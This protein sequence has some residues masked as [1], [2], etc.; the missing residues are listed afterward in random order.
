MVDWV[1]S[2]QPRQTKHRLYL[3]LVVQQALRKPPCHCSRLVQVE[4]RVHRLCKDQ[5]FLRTTRVNAQSRWPIRAAD[6]NLAK[7]SAAPNF[8]FGSAQA[9]ASPASQPFVFGQNEA[10]ATSPWNVQSAGQMNAAGG[11]P[12]STSTPAKFNFSAPGRHLSTFRRPVL[13]ILLRLEYFSLEQPLV[14]SQSHPIR[15]A[16]R[17]RITLVVRQWRIGSLRRASDERPLLN[18]KTWRP[19]KCIC[20]LMKTSFV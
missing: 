15:S 20:L 18:D 10:L 4:I 16:W 1:R 11:A 5:P 14:A 17:L 13:S 6:T 12:F 19:W 3:R 8:A 2:V 9:A 7:R